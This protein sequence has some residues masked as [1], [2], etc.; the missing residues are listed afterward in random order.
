MFC[1][2]IPGLLKKLGVSE[3][4]PDEWRLL[5]DSSKY[6]LNV[7]LLHNGNPLGSVPIAHSTIL[8]E[9]YD[10]VK[11]VL[12]NIKYDEH[13]WKICVDLKMVNFLLG[14][15][16]GFTKFPCFLCHWDSRARA[17]HW[18]RKDWPE[19]TDM[20]VGQKNVIAEPLVDRSNIIFP[21]LH[22]KLGLMKQ[23]VK[24]LDK[25]GDCFRYICESFPALSI[26]KKKV[27]VHNYVPLRYLKI[28]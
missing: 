11:F 2:D 5:I 26:E 1:H 13:S 4:K 28:I 18:E 22:I 21:P 9:T 19:R 10:A 27:G 14:Q 24:A 6:S 25:D 23:F 20:V 17:E 12:L 16:S 3:Y 8:K 7:V 15:Q